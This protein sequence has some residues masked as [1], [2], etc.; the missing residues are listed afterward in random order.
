MQKIAVSSVLILLSVFMFGCAIQSLNPFCFPED[1][2]SV[3]EINGKWK[4]V[5]EN[6]EEGKRVEDWNIEADR[7]ICYDE[8]NVK[9]ILSVKFFKIEKILF[10]DLT[11]GEPVEDKALFNG[12]WAACVVPVHVVA[13]FAVSGDELRIIPA[14]YLAVKQKIEEGI[15]KLSHVKRADGGILLTADTESLKKFISDFKDDAEV[16]QQKKSLLLKSIKTQNL[17]GK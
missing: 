3:P 13:K 5:Y 8:N 6:L 12:Y 1:A 16:F 15:I 4:P 17:V 2:I 9:S 14:D 11:A 10:A 7:I